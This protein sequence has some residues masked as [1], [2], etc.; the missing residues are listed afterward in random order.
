MP[1]QRWEGR[2]NE[3]LNVVEVIN[4]PDDASPRGQF[5]KVLDSFLTGKVQARH[6]DEIMNAKPWH[7]TDN[8]RVFFRSEDLFIYLEARRFRYTTQHQIWSWLREAGGDRSQFRIKNKAVKVWSV[9]APEFYEEE[10]LEIPTTVEEE[11]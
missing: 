3:L 9:P 6:R 2:I 7:D 5:E 10:D 8:D 4:D 11:F 1:Q